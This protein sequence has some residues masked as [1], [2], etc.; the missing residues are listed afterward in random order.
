MSRKYLGDR[1]DIHGGG[2]DLVFPH[3][4]NE[5]AQS[6]SLNKQS[7]MAN[8]WVHNGHLSINGA[9]MSKSAGNFFTVNDMLQKYDGEVIRMA[10]LMT[11]Y[12]APQSFSVDTLNQAKNILDH[13]YSSIQSTT[14][15]ETD[16]II[17]DVLD[18]LLDNLNTPLAIST[19]SRARETGTINQ[20]FVA[21][22]RNLLGVMMKDPEDWF[23]NVSD[24]QREWI[25]SK[26]AE[27]AEAKRLKDYV[28]ADAIRDAL[29][30]G[31]ITIEDT[32]DGSTWKA[33]T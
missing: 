7:T 29:L 32:K 22:C 19:L 4:E 24:R 21:T 28:T 26:I 17:Q 14:Y 8:Y 20:H 10:L 33:N 3:H 30:E 5:I 12:S 16:E 15:V 1:F 11:H 13:W 25:N 18:A 27:R 6:C 23:C 31:G 9:K 2:I